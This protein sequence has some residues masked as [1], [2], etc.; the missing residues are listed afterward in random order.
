MD[1]VLD[2]IGNLSDSVTLSVVPRFRLPKQAAFTGPFVLT[3]ATVIAGTSCLREISASFAAI[4]LAESSAE[5]LEQMLVAK[6]VEIIT[7]EEVHFII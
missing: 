6:S 2:P 5:E 1:L 3:T 4:S 7:I